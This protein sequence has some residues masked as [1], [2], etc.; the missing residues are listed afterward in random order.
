MLLG[1][2]M[3]PWW[4]SHIIAWSVCYF[5][6][7]NEIHRLFTSLFLYCL[8]LLFRCF[9]LLVYCYHIN[10]QVSFNLRVIL[11]VAKITRSATTEL[12][13]DNP[14]ITCWSQQALLYVHRSECSLH[15]NR[16]RN[17]QRR[18]LCVPVH[19]PWNSVFWVHWQRHQ[20]TLVCYNIKLWHWRNVGT[21]SW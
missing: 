19:L 12:H 9:S 21:L 20:E 8:F 7:E 16:R 13:S 14:L 11:Y 2:T 1:N 3:F 17:K 4:H 5:W 6:L 15:R 18:V 10:F